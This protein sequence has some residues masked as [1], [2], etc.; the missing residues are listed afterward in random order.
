MIGRAGRPQYDTSAVAILFV[1]DIKKEYYKK[2]LYEPFPVESHLLEVF[3]DHLNAEVIS[4]TVSSKSEAMEYLSST[5]LY[6]RILK[7]PSYYG[8]DLSNLGVSTEN[9][10]LSKLAI[11]QEV[12]RYLSS[13]IDKC[14]Q[15]LVDDYCVRLVE[16]GEKDLD[17]DEEA[18]YF[19]PNPS[20]QQRLLAT[21]LGKICSFYYLT[22]S[23]VRLFQD[24]LGTM[25]PDASPDQLPYL[26]LSSVLDLLSQAPEFA[27]LPVR[28]NEE[29]LNEKLAHQTP[30]KIHR[31]AMDSPH[32]KTHLLLQAHI[33]RL[34]LPIVDYYTDLKSVLDQALRILQAMLDVSALNGSL[35]TTL[36]IIALQQ[37]IMQA[38]WLTSE[39]SGS[40][41]ALLLSMDEENRPKP[42]RNQDEYQ[43]SNPLNDA[44]E[45]LD[46]HS[47]G[48][49]KNRALEEVL[50]VPVDVACIPYLLNIVHREEVTNRSAPN[51]NKQSASL[52]SILFA[53]HLSDRTID[54]LHKSLLRLPLIQLDQ[55]KIVQI[56]DSD[57]NT[58]ISANKIVPKLETFSPALSKNWIQLNQETNYNLHVNLKRISP[59]SVGRKTFGNQ[60]QSPKAFTP[61][62]PKPKSESW[63]LVLGCQQRHELITMSRVANIGSN[64][65]NQ[66]VLQFKTPKVVNK[67]GERILYTL[68]LLSDCYVG[69]D[70][71]YCLPFHVV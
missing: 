39:G 54:R 20:T 66:F 26:T 29:L 43:E 62:F 23:T 42:Q 61:H 32:T 70:Q 38:S 57:E 45:Y 12:I 30:I 16:E 17:D 50:Q 59:H 27:Q 10:S 58:K 67:E 5:Y 15:V 37:S 52:K 33:S 14:V 69:L 41:L 6:H 56:Q 19:N 51:K 53:H 64:R 8:V 63:Y 13:F 34:P 18:V 47:V 28:H 31:R 60:Q 9:E 22:H 55:M 48:R 2:F 11:N 4:G 71:Q 25:N 46:S 3:P 68:Y 40:Q 1:H 44:S 21:P 65:S 7:N 49:V 24:T 36:N 35:P